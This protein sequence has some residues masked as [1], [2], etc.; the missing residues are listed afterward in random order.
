MPQRRTDAAIRKQLDAVGEKLGNDRA[1][2]E[3]RLELLRRQADL[4]DERDAAVLRTRRAA[5]DR[6]RQTG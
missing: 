2:G 1:K 4:G 5:Q 3:K 6:K